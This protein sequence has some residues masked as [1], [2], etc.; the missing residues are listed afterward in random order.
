MS[1]KQLLQMNIRLLLVSLRDVA[2]RHILQKKQ[3]DEK[4]AEQLDEYF[5]GRLLR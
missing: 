4:T 2:L 3:R 5:L 1:M